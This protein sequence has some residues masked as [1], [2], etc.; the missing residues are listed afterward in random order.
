MSSMPTEVVP[1]PA[2]PADPLILVRGMAGAVAGGV[3]GYFLFRLLYKNGLYGIMIPGALLGLGAGL[4][5]RGKS[6]PLGILCAV[7]AVG[8]GILSEWTIGPFKKDPSLAFFVTHVHHLPAVKLMLMA[9]GAACA[10]WFGQ[11]R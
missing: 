8:L 2:R 9:L 1:S 10:Y 5:A 3:I 11:G 4:A 7:A 6:A